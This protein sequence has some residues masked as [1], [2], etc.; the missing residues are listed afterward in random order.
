MALLNAI[1]ML[2]SIL[3]IMKFMTAHRK[4]GIVVRLVE[5]VF[6]TVYPFLSYF[7]GLLVMFSCISKAL[8]LEVAVD[9]EPDPDDDP[10]NL[11]TTIPVRGV[12]R[13][14]LM[15][16]RNSVGDLETPA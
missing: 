2:L 11:D 15:T 3:S 8:G 13:Y 6:N 14:F 7:T 1:L 5:Q 16:C 12:W 9:A 4:F 10:E